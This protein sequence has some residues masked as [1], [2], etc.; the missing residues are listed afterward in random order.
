[1]ADFDVIV[2]GAGP[3]GEVVAGRLAKAGLS[4]AIVERELVGG[5]C[6]YYA[7]MPSKALLR[8]AELLDEVARVPGAAQALSGRIDPAAT[9]ARRDEVI[10]DLDDSAQ[11]PWIENLGISLIRGCGRLAPPGDGDRRVSV[12]ERT[13]EAGRAV[14]IATGSAAAMP[15]IPGLDDVAPWT[16][17]EATTVK[18]VPD[19]LLI[20]GGGVVGVEL[21]QAW[22]SLGS[23][24]VI[25]E[26]LPRLLAREEPFA[27]EQVADALRERGVEIH[28]GS[29]AT[30]VGRG[31]DGFRLTLETGAELAGREL[32]VAVGRRPR[33]DD[34]GIDAF[35]LEPGK[36]IDVD[37]QMRVPGYDWLFAI[38]DVNGRTL[39][40]HMGK[41]QAR[42]AAD[43]IL[44]RD[45]R[46][47]EDGAR[48]PRVVYTD[49]QVAAVGLTLAGA[50]DQGIQARAV[51]V[52]TSG[53]AGASFYGRGTAGTARIVVDEVRGVIVGATFTGFETAEFIHAA[54]IA[55]VGEVP[56][57][58][59][60]HAIPAFPTRSE[61]WLKL[62]EAYGL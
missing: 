9:L 46:V 44:G 32:L 15:P 21:A 27:G 38:G 58:R 30:G 31:D 8:P 60:W 41:Y 17:R 50:L 33:T 52:D 62:L 35:G 23:G 56:L 51:D 36:T 29:K 54:T 39:L 45:A 28:L 57:D 43:V 20:L 48:S 11:L 19:S 47:T 59:L 12:G 34:I 53:T 26:S 37:D 22:S 61:L 13:Y 7:C 16:N 3:A 1:M 6:A 42:A 10:H 25:V 14:V 40:T 49:P 5:E 4:V 55:V 24:V 2:L 18:E